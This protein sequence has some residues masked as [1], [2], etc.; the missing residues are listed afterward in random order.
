MIAS[1]KAGDNDTVAMNLFFNITQQVTLTMEGPG[2][3]H[4]S[5]YYEAIKSDNDDDD[6]A[7]PEVV[8]KVVNHE[9]E[10]DLDALIAS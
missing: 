10:G 8:D 1:L 3:V 5:G 7:E 9:N 6:K 2:E 4:L